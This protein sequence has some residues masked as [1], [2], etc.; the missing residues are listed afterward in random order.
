MEGRIAVYALHAR[1]GDCFVVDF[2]NGHALLIDG[3]FKENCRK[4]L[5]PLFPLFPLCEKN[6]VRK[7][8]VRIVIS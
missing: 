2:G 8:S 4:E 5:I 7:N 3:G 6:S 1:G